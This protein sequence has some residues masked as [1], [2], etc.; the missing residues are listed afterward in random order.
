MIHEA[1]KGE[2]EKISVANLGN[3]ILYLLICLHHFSYKDLP[4][5]PI[6]TSFGSSA[7]SVS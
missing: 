7:Y 1:K 6:Y 5:A 3:V 4:P 2:N